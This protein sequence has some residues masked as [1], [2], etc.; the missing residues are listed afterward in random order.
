MMDSDKV[1]NAT[2]N[3]LDKILILEVTDYGHVEIDG[4]SYTSIAHLIES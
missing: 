4:L 1:I 3:K 2:F